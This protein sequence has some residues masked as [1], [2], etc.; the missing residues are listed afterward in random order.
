MSFITAAQ[1]NALRFLSSIVDVSALFEGVANEIVTL[2]AA[3]AGVVIAASPTMTSI[4]GVLKIVDGTGSVTP[5][6]ATTDYIVDPVTRKFKC[7]TKQDGAASKL[8]VYYR[9]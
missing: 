7:V 4:K 1:R 6:V 9:P 8:V 5:L 3:D 2:T